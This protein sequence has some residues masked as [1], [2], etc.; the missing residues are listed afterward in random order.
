[1]DVEIGEP[2][3]GEIKVKTKAIGLNFI[4]VYFR[5]GFYKAPTMPYTPGPFSL[6]FIKIDIPSSARVS[7]NDDFNSFLCFVSLYDR[8]PKPFFPFMS[9]NC[10]YYH[11]KRINE[12]NI[13]FVIEECHCLICSQLVYL[14]QLFISCILSTP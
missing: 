11:K 6:C 4:D 9:W 12:S 14:A 10:F 2:K 3:Q 5:K 1:M 8:V 7:L 13:L